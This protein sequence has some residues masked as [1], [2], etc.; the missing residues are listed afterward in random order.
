MDKG[1]L[2]DKVRVDIKKSISGIVPYRTLPYRT[3]PMILLYDKSLNDSWHMY[4]TVPVRYHTKNYKIKKNNV[5][6]FIFYCM[7]NLPDE[8]LDST[9]LRKF[10][11]TGADNE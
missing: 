10:L 3:V 5:L 11:R 6:I 1:V 2:P 9:S 4:G 7:D 8:E